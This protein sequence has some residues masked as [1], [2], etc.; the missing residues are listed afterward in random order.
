MRLPAADEGRQR[1]G[2]SGE[3]RERSDMATRVRA[4]TAGANGSPARAASR[5]TAAALAQDR[6]ARIKA[7][8]FTVLRDPF[9]PRHEDHMPRLS[10]DWTLVEICRVTLE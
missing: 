4:R 10:G 8:S 1:A 3:Q 9:T 5:G 2:Q 6:G 7:V